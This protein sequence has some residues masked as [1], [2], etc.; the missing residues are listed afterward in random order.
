MAVAAPESCAVS[1]TA[2]PTATRTAPGNLTIRAS[3]CRVESQK[4][5]CIRP[6]MHP[7][8]TP[9]R[10]PRRGPRAWR[11]CPSLTY[12]RYC[13]PPCTTRTVRTP[14]V[15]SSRLASRAPRRPVRQ[16]TSETRHWGAHILARG[17]ACARISGAYQQKVMGSHQALDRGF[18]AVPTERPP[19]CSKIR[20]SS[21]ASPQTAESLPAA[22]SLH[23]VAFLTAPLRGG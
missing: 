22:A 8:S 20:S 23:C 19:Y 9:S 12:S 17:A 15:W 13:T 2:M 21:E 10:L 11:R 5:V 4:F 14:L 6:A 16:R 18:K 1:H 7:S 3:S